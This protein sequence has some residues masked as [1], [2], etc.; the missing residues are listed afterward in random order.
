M[1]EKIIAYK[2]MNADMTCRG[3]QYE[4]GKTHTEP[5][6]KCCTTTN[7]TERAASLK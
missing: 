5:V 6:A 3:K 2:G 4:I 1:S 7:R